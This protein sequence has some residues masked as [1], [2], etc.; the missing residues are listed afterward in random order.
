MLSKNLI[1]AAGEY[2]VCAEL[3]R[4]GI[5]ALVTPKNNK[6]IDVL[7]SDVDGYRTVSIQVKTMSITNEQGWKFGQLEKKNNPNLYFVLVNMLNN[8]TNDF[9]IY[10]YDELVERDGHALPITAARQVTL[11]VAYAAHPE[12]FPRGRPHPPVV[13][14]QAGINLPMATPDCP[15]APTPKDGCSA[16]PSAVLLPADALGSRVS[17]AASAPRDARASAGNPGRWG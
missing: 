10:R 4:R 12:R 5:L 14:D 1:G 11:D 17:A 3:C 9:Y 8:G 6:L 2:Y 7:A 13:P 16:D 15:A